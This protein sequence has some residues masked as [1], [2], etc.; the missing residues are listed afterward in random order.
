MVALPRNLH[1]LG[2]QLLAS[3]FHGA[4]AHFKGL[5][6]TVGEFQELGVG[7]VFAVAGDAFHVKRYGWFVG[8]RFISLQPNIGVAVGVPIAEKRGPTILTGRDFQSCQLSACVLDVGAGRISIRV[9]IRGFNICCALRTTS[10]P[11]IY[12]HHTAWY[13]IIEIQRG[14]F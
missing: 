5:V 6:C 11:I 12:R 3:T 4:P 13:D 2:I 1:S 7:M 9:V 8:Y 10:R 14:A